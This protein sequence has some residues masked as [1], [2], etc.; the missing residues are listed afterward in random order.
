MQKQQNTP[1][2][3]SK[4]SQPPGNFWAQR[5]NQSRD[6]SNGRSDSAVPQQQQQSPATAGFNA[7][8]VKAF[9]A[10]D[11]AGVSSATYKLQEAGGK[12]S[13]GAGG[14]A[15]GA[16][17][18]EFFSAGAQRQCKKENGVANCVFC[19]GGVDAQTASN[20]PFFALLAKQIATLE[21]GG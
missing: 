12:G 13:G 17:K 21:G 19:S 20:Q 2:Q 16:N 10:R 4:P 8:E 15:K 18:C 7:A 1:T 14:G 11:A 9:L 6:S 5:A 3:T